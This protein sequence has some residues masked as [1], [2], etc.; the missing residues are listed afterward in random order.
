MLLLKD[1]RETLAGR[2]TL[3]NLF[4][5]SLSE[6]LV[7]TTP[8]LLTKIWHEGKLT[9]SVVKGLTTLPPERTRRAQS[10]TREHQIWGGYPP[11]WQSKDKIER[12]NWLKDYR[13]TY[14]ERDILDVGR[15]ANLDTF[16]L[17][18]K[19]LCARTG[20]LLSVSEVARDLSLAV[21]T[22][23]RYINLL[24]MS[25]QCYLLPPFHQNISKRLVKSPKIY[26]PDVGLNQAILGEMSISSGVAYETWAFSELVKWKHLQP[27]EPELLFYRTAGGRELDF[28]IAG[29]GTV[30]P[31]EV[32]SSAKVSSADGRHIRSFMAEN[33][34]LT[35]M[36]LIVYSGR[37]IVEIE[38]D[39]WAVPDWL[40]F[41]GL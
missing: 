5:F 8:P 6:L 41:G 14:L 34:R 25:F 24:K 39:I 16:A 27:E 20:Q 12:I 7:S 21:N 3:S 11:V 15:I 29:K 13:K 32:K 28:L 30:L 26:F 36:G 22:V 35:S 4:P 10:L 1:I 9:K 19:L 17:A 40:L 31:L 33:E 18:Q 23:K 38:K 2:I 37:E